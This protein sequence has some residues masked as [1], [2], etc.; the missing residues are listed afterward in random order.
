MSTPGRAGER[1][2]TAND[3]GSLAETVVAIVVLAVTA[4]MVLSFRITITNVERRERLRADAVALIEEAAKA[5]RNVD[6]V[7]HA[8]QSAVCGP[9][10]TAV[11]G[12]SRDS[13]GVLEQQPGEVVRPAGVGPGTSGHKLITIEWA[14]YYR[15]AD[16]GS[17]DRRIDPPVDPVECRDRPVPAGTWTDGC[18]ATDDP[19]RAVREITAT[20]RDGS[21]LRTLTRTALGPSVPLTRGWTARPATGDV[22]GVVPD[23]ASTPA[24]TRESYGY[25]LAAGQYEDV[26]V[27]SYGGCKVLVARPGETVAAGYTKCV[28]KEGW[29]DPDLS[30]I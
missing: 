19:P 17:C 21:G 23:S 2:R 24:R 26:Q 25:L 28:L 16:M 15:L 10:V 4:A 7:Q 29:N 8:G 18:G 14:D 5:A 1:E 20:W 3:D 12:T 11:S 9:P 13:N 6:C 30:C 22:T 27:P